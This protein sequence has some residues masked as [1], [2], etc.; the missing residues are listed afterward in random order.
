[1][2]GRVRA[3]T[4]V[5]ERIR[6]VG[7]RT[8]RFATSTEA[9]SASHSADGRWRPLARHRNPSLTPRNVR[10]NRGH[11]WCSVEERHVYT[12]GHHIPATTGGAAPPTSSLSYRRCA[13][14]TVGPSLWRCHRSPVGCRHAALRG[15]WNAASVRGLRS[16][17]RAP[18]TVPMR[19]CVCV[20]VSS[21]AVSTTVGGGFLGHRSAA[22]GDDGLAC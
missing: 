18:S 20:N 22:L 3:L 10:V 4:I 17:R 1:V 16:V 13:R 11:G 14:A 12:R 19:M 15:T 8:P 2:D 5:I 7:E 6:A 21:D 9:G